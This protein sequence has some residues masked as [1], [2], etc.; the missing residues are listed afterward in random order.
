MRVFRK[1]KREAEQSR[2]STPADSERQRAIEEHG[3][4]V[5]LVPNSVPWGYSVGINRSFR[6]PELLI[7]GLHLDDIH[8]LCNRYGEAVRSGRKLSPG[9][10]LEDWMEGETLRLLTIEDQ[11]KAE[12]M[13]IAVDEHGNASFAAMQAVWS[14]GGSYP[15]DTQ[16]PADL[17][18]AQ[19]LLGT[20][21]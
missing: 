10:T 16:W 2:P 17:E 18:G 8:S 12:F 13:G 15:W 14:K 1:F 4:A 9:D 5:I 3:W 7:V 19:F 6:A 20:A 21:Q 11:W